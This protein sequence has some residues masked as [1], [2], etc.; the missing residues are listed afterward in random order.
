MI[1][2]TTKLPNNFPGQP[3]LT[4][5]RNKRA[6][7]PSPGERPTQRG[8]VSRAWPKLPAPLTSRPPS[9]APSS[10]PAAR[11]HPPASQPHVPI[12]AH[13]PFAARSAHPP[14]RAA[15]PTPPHPDWLLSGAHHRWDLLDPLVFPPNY[16]PQPRTQA[17]PHPRPQERAE[18]G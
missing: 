8:G 6:H 10:R 17:V 11:V 7:V 2:V 5:E 1:Q 3:V 12:S 15:R 16:P 13:V 4:K 14:S 18:P 9:A